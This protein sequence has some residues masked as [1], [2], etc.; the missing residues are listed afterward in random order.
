MLL[1]LPIWD[2]YS[3]ELG[4]IEK[5]INDNYLDANYIVDDFF[6]KKLV[7]N[8]KKQAFDELNNKVIVTGY[9]G[10]VYSTLGGMMYGNLFGINLDVLNIKPRF[11][12][13][14]FKEIERL[15][16][17]VNMNSSY[18]DDW[19]KKSEHEESRTKIQRFFG[20]NKFKDDAINTKI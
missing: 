3:A 2:K 14:N 6:G 1:S 17:S 13:D 16:F 19:I 11:F 7:F 20:L 8:I 5:E 15:G 12:K 9:G 4:T 18:L 10:D